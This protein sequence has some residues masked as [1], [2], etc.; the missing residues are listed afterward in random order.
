MSKIADMSKIPD[1]SKIADTRNQ[2]GAVGI[3]EASSAQKLKE[4]SRPTDKRPLAVWSSETKEKEKSPKKHNGLP[5]Q[6]SKSS[7]S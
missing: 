6:N 1:T 7:N 4:S 5:T 2:V 3:K